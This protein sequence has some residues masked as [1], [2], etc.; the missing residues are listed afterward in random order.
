[1]IEVDIVFSRNSI[2]AKLS[3]AGM[4]DVI[5]VERVNIYTSKI[6]CFSFAWFGIYNSQ[7]DVVYTY[8]RQAGMKRRMPELWYNSTRA[9]P[10]SRYPCGNSN[11]KQSS[12]LPLCSQ[13]DVCNCYARISVTGLLLRCWLDGSPRRGYMYET[14]LWPISTRYQIIPICWGDPTF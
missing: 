3:G 10:A 12:E 1:M 11:F 4:E 14:V 13:R 8:T 7:F 9:T 6:V 5:Y 2:T